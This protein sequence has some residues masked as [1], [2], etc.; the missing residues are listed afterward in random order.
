M[1]FN[2]G[3]IVE[4]KGIFQL[5]LVTGVI[6]DNEKLFVTDYLNAPSGEVEIMFNEVVNRW[7]KKAL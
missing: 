4:V 6:H 5:Q 2:I 3:D 1:E 7:E